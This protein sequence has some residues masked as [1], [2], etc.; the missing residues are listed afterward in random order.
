[1]FQTI[2][3]MVAFYVALK[4]GWEVL[5]PVVVSYSA[6]IYVVTFLYFAAW[7]WGRRIGLRYFSGAHRSINEGHV[8]LWLRDSSLMAAV[9]A[10][11]GLGFLLG[12][13]YLLATHHA[14]NALLFAVLGL[15][16]F[17][18]VFEVWSKQESRRQP[19]A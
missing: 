18:S 11:F 5:A 17:G 13:V 4:M 3:S 16:L 10:Y 6:T 12:G 19:Q 7:W 2:V 1:M 8:Y 9:M 14:F 15:G